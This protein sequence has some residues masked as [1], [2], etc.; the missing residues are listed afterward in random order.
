MARRPSLIE[1]FEFVNYTTISRTTAPD[2]PATTPEDPE[3]KRLAY[4]YTSW[5]TLASECHRVTTT[6]NESIRSA[7]SATAQIRHHTL[8]KSWSGPQWSE[9]GLP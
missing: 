5:V 3:T 1:K 8:R 6:Q 7:T 4:G 2:K 9:L